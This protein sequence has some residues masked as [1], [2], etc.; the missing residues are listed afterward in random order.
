MA[1]HTLIRLTTVIVVVGVAAIAAVVS[2]WHMKELALSVGEQWRS[3][4]IPLTIDGLVVS[5]SMVLVTRKR[6]GRKP[7]ELAWGALAVGVVASVAANILDAK[8]GI[9][10]VLM[11]GWAPLAFAVC[12][13]LLLQQR[14]SEATDAK[15]TEAMQPS[16]LELPEQTKPVVLPSVTTTLSMQPLPTHRVGEP[17]EPIASTSPVTTE[18]ASTATPRVVTPA[19]TLQPVPELSHLRRSSSQ[20]PSVE[21][22]KGGPQKKVTAEDVKRCLDRGL[23]PHQLPG[24]LKVSKP[25]IDRRL[26]ELRE[27]S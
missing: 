16:Q 24:V 23:R 21:P 22:H 7:S 10:A 27:S 9:T 1:S 3:Y 6:E 4:L 2:F 19:P 26:R 18:P 17:R 5:A 8:P 11:A 15:S 13:E 20:H 12:F 14:R 25:T